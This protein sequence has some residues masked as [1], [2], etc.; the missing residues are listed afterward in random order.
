[1]LYTGARRG[2]IVALEWAH[3]DF[4]TGTLELPVKKGGARKRHP[5]G[6]VALE[7][8]AGINR[9]AGSPWVFPRPADPTRHVTVEVVE[10]AW[11]RLRHRADLADVHLHDLRHTV[12]TYAAQTGANAFAVR[13]LLR[14]ASVA[15]TGRYVNFDADPVRAMSDVIGERISAGLEAGASAKVVP[16]KKPRKS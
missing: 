5:I 15:M 6:A 12:G 8:F 14:H 10:N 11:Q 9:V 16:L 2:E 13:N 3:V 7:L 1:M 4:D